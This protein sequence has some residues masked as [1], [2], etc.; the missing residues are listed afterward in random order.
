MGKTKAAYTAVKHDEGEQLGLLG[1][2][3]RMLAEANQT[4]GAFAAVEITVRPGG[5]APPHVDNAEAIAWYVLDG[6]LDFM[7]EGDVTSLEAGGW[8]N[9]PKGV[10]H[11]FHNSTDVPARALLLMVPSGLDGFFREV[12]RDA[13]A[14]RVSERAHRSR[15]RTGDGSGAAL[16]RR[17]PT[18]TDIGH[19]TPRRDAAGL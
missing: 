9:L 14:W 16:W 15:H 4:D 10:L 18:A 8:I 1:D 11:T 5:G 12:G 19:A 13:R 17:H 3:Y 6:T 7:V 2:R